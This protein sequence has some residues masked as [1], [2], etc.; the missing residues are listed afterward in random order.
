[1]SIKKG[2]EIASPTIDTTHKEIS[3]MLLR[4]LPYALTVCKVLS[5][6]EINLYADFFF[7]GKTDEELS[8]VCITSDVPVHTTNR[9]DGWRGFRIEGELGFAPVSSLSLLS[10]LLFDHHIDI[11]A[12]STFNTDYILVKEAQFDR[13]IGVLEKEGYV[14]Q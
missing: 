9:N 1:M 8:L 7:I 2:E 13:A 11:F 12:V 5:P 6:A 4:K 14:I 10:A 3:P